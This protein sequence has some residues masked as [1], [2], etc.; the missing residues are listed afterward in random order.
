MKNG[1]NI[2]EIWTDADADS[3]MFLAILLNIINKFYYLFIFSSFSSCP[4]NLGRI[5]YK[6]KIFVKKRYV[7]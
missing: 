5:I 7:L 1:I 2:F 3:S 4:D 6:L